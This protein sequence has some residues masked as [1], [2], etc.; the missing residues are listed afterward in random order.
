MNKLTTNVEEKN[1]QSNVMN[2]LRVGPIMPFYLLIINVEKLQLNQK[3]RLCFQHLM[4]K[5][6]C[7]HFC[8][9][10]TNGSYKY[11][12]LLNAAFLKRRVQ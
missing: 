4:N 2:M 3:V 1:K 10:M 12:N 7:S 5:K 8:K 9:S 11:L 6:L